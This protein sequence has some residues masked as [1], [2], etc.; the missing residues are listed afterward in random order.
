[1]KPILI[2]LLLIGSAPATS[3]HFKQWLPQYR[4]FFEPLVRTKCKVIHKLYERGYGEPTLCNPPAYEGCL[5]GQMV[6][7]LLE[8]ATESIKANMASA[9]VFLSLLPSMLSLV[10]SSTVEI[11]LLALKRP[12]LASLLALG[13]PA[14][15]PVRFAEYRDP[16]DMLQRDKSNL[17]RFVFPRQYAAAVSVVE[18]LLACIAIANIA[19]LS[20]Q[21]GAWAVCGF[22]S[23]TDW[24][25]ALWAVLAFPLHIVGTWA[26]ML[27][28]RCEA[29]GTKARCL[30][31]GD[32]WRDEWRLCTQH[33]PWRMCVKDESLSFIMLSWLNSVA[34]VAHIFLGTAVFASTLFISTRDSIVVLAR[35]MASTIVCRIVLRFEIVGMRNVVEL[36]SGGS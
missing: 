33:Q 18:Y 32:R 26:V 19:H 22:S 7:C 17:R 14:V 8:G 15:A 24:L 10:G 27:R 2:L 36:G 34:N 35:Y 9:T 4:P 21:L 31:W 5:S 25:P 3:S 6:R 20:W 11:G 23:D 1:M 12:L 16:V 28:Y 30:C 29:I 13:A